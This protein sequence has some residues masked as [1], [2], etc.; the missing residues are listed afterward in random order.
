M[1]P[2]RVAFVLIVIANL[3]G[4]IRPVDTSSNVRA[5]TPILTTTSATLEVEEIVVADRPGTAP[6]FAHTIDERSK[7]AGL[8]RLRTFPIDK[9]DIE[10]RIWAGFGLTTL[11]GYVLKRQKGIWSGNRLFSDYVHDKFIERT[12]SLK[13]P[14]NGW[15]ALWTD[16]KGHRVLTLPDAELINCNGQMEDGFSFVVEIRKGRAYRTYSYENADNLCTEASDMSAIY[17]RIL[18][19]FN[20]KSANKNR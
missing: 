6:R 20:F 13:S 9:D 1:C 3:I 11:E 8:K 15:D 18:A 7:A 4:C 12:A 19:D 2:M 5:P 14:Q 17:H 16:L 10:L